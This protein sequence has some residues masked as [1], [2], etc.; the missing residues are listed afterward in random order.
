MALLKLN[1][2]TKT[3]PSS[4]GRRVILNNISLDIYSN[5]K[6]AVIGASGSGKTSLAK[7]IKGYIS[8]TSGS[9]LFKDN[10]VASSSQL[11]T[12]TKIQLVFQDPD[13]S[14]TPQRIVSSSIVEFLCSYKGLSKTDALMKL[15]SL[16]KELRITPAQLNKYPHELSGGE[17]QRVA[18]IRALLAEPEILVCDEILS[19]LD[20]P[21]QEEVLN[22]L[23]KY[24]KKSAFALIFISHDLSLLT[25]FF[26]EAIIVDNAQIVARGSLSDLIN[27][28]TTDFMKKSSEALSWLL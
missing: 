7:I 24:Q 15:S 26:D 23:I 19:A 25:K 9:V 18:L 14:L 17:K 27:S 11:L 1:Q 8:P 13:Q 22:L 16:S 21:L 10:K 20:Q 6:L 2:I 3:A 5:K 4:K 12:N 28:P